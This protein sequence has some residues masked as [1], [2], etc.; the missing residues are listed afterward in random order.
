VVGNIVQEAYAP[1]VPRYAD[2]QLFQG[3]EEK[4]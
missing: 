1:T 4:S 2:N 3:M